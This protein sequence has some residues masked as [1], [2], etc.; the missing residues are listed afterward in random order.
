M[1][2]LCSRVQ[3]KW[4]ERNLVE[5]VGANLEESE[6]LFGCWRFIL[7]FVWKLD[8]LHIPNPGPLLCDRTQRLCGRIENLGWEGED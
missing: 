4:G 7:R 3:R 2:I 5:D 6:G 1:Q 8:L